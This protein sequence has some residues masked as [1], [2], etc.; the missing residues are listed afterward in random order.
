MQLEDADY[1]AGPHRSHGHCI[2]R[3]C[4][5]VPMMK[6]IYGKAGG[7]CGGKGGSMHIADLGKGLLGAN[8]I[9]GAG[10]PMACGAALTAKT[11]RTGAVAVA[12]AGDGAAN[13]GTACESLNLASVWR[14][15]VIFV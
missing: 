6:E 1:I 2:A 5:V 4:D 11:L 15:P 14:L 8:G 12:F 7:V 3:G 9:T 13:Q 10:L